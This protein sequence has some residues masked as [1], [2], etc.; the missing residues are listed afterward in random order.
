MSHLCNSQDIDSALHAS[1]LCMPRS[2][3]DQW[4]EALLDIFPGTEQTSTWSSQ[5]DAYRKYLD[6]YLETPEAYQQADDNLLNLLIRVSMPSHAGRH[7]LPFTSSFLLNPACLRRVRSSEALFQMALPPPQASRKRNRDDPISSQTDSDALALLSAWGRRSMVVMH[8]DVTAG[9]EPVPIPV[10]L[11]GTAVCNGVE[12]FNAYPICG[13]IL[14]RRH[15]GERGGRGEAQI[16]E[17]S[18]KGLAEAPWEADSAAG[19]RTGAWGPAAGPGGAQTGVS[20]GDGSRGG[21][22]RRR[23]GKGGR[24]DGI[25][26]ERSGRNGVGAEE[27]PLTADEVLKLLRGQEGNQHAGVTGIRLRGPEFR[28]STRLHPTSPEE[29]RALHMFGCRSFPGNVFTRHSD[30]PTGYQPAF[31]L[32]DPSRGAT[33]RRSAACCVAVCARLSPLP[34]GLDARAAALSC[35]QFPLARP[36]LYI[37]SPIT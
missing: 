30:F 24:K 10:V 29:L 11:P 9:L 33:A 13:A 6:K 7:P 4:P 8:P 1:Y 27:G 12:G 14:S 25:S 2:Y 17:D 18:R 19:T 32:P 5:A 23:T 37:I 34:L 22:K 36:S 16:A 26:W 31:R 3:L 35:M 21:E 15:A 28:Y 20:G